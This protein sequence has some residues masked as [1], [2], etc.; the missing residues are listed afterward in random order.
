MVRTAGT[1]VAPGSL[2]DLPEATWGMMLRRGLPQ[3]GAENVLPVLGFYAVWRFAGLG[4]AVVASTVVYLALAA[5]LI[6][7]GRE[8][9]AIAIGMVF[10]AVQAV[11]GLVSN[12]AT[13][14]LAQPV[15]LSALWGLA[16]IGSA[17]LGKPLIGV[18]ANAWYPFPDWFR[19]AGPYR[20]EFA[21]QSVVWGVYFLVRAALRLWVLLESGVGGFVLV[22]VP[23]GTPLLI[24]LVV[25]GIWHARR[26]FSRL[27]DHDVALPVVVHAH[28]KG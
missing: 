15:V 23:T 16:L 26:T 8:V 22:S 19:A 11:V 14:Y 2:N 9:G 24:A 10:V 21:M 12:S 25:W 6:R 3:F 5:W 18:F 7:S 17:A 27:Q 1:P 20:R 4:P 13:V 28:S